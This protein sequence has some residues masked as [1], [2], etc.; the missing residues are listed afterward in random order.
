MWVIAVN[1]SS[2]SLGAKRDFSDLR[3]LEYSMVAYDW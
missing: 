3:S 2:Q 1:I